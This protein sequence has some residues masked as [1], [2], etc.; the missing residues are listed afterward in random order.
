VEWVLPDHSK[1]KKAGGGWQLADS[2]RHALHWMRRLP[3][4]LVCLVKG[5]DTVLQFDR[6]RLALRCT[7]C[8]RHT[9]GWVIDR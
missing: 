1:L 9:A 2:L 8:G 6:H 7:T 5:H 4:R 3:K